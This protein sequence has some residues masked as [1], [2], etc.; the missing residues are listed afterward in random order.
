MSVSCRHNQEMQ[1]MHESASAS[2]SSS[3]MILSSAPCS[4][5]EG[6]L[7]DIAPITPLSAGLSLSP[8]SP[9]FS[10]WASWGHQTNKYAHSSSCL[11]VRFR[12]NQNGTLG[13]HFLGRQEGLGCQVEGQVDSSAGADGKQSRREIK[14][15]RLCLLARW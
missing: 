10:P 11:R 14:G 6:P 5:P 4:L 3:R 7:S 2:L 15:K 12:G 8:P 9:S 13:V 1:R